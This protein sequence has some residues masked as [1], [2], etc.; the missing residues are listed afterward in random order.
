M[1]FLLLGFLG[2]FLEEFGGLDFIVKFLDSNTLLIEIMFLKSSMSLRK[3]IC[4]FFICKC[5]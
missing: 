4:G 2:L 5:N 3:V 1:I